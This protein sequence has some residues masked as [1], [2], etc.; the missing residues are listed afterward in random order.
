MLLHLLYYFLG[1]D[2]KKHRTITNAAF[3]TKILEKYVEIFEKQSKIL[4]KKL[5]KDVG[6]PSV[7]IQSN[8]ALCT[9]DI[10][11]GNYLSYLFF[12]YY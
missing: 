4:V 3:H 9:L 8:V 12:N 10:I 6:K 1:M 2:W 11:C 7:H 5:K